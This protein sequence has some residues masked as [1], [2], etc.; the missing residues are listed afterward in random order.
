MEGR[1]RKRMGRGER[2]GKEGKRKESIIYNNIC[3]CICIIYNNI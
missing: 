3:I 2:E 1:D